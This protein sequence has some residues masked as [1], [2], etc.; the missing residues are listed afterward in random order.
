M[1]P[2]DVYYG[3]REEI[4]KRRA[5][6]KEH[7]IVRRLEYNLNRCEPQPGGEPALEL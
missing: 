7:T 1:T 5:E 6:Q 3:W 2:A 4:L